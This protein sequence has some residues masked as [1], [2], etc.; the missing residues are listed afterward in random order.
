[1]DFT[2]IDNF[3]S[4]AANAVARYKIEFILSTEQL[5]KDDYCVPDLTWNSIPYGDQEIDKVPNDKRGIYAFAV[6][7]ESNVLPSHCYVLYIGI[8]GRRS[9]RSLRA[10]YRDYLNA[11]KILKRD[12]IA[13]MIG[14]WRPVLRF[15]FAS[16]DEAMTGTELETLEK[17]LN[18]AL[19]PP[20]AEGD[21]EAVIKR[22][23]RAFK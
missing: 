22:Q 2:E 13:Q 12:R 20:K 18:A 6:C 5:S 19:L 21:L 9:N 14:T 11:K 4:G 17:Q 3:A 23:R 7:K 10:R 1:M 16:V 8:A 15:F